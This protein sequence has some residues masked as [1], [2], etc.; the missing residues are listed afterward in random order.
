MT[1]MCFK[2]LLSN[3]P[4]LLC[5]AALCVPVIQLTIMTCL[6]YVTQHAAIAFIVFTEVSMSY[7]WW[8]VYR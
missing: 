5:R 4:H 7:F 6:L 2:S 1:D 3:R 8:W